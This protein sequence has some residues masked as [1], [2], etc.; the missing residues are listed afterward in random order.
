MASMVSNIF[1]LECD[2]TSALVKIHSAH[3]TDIMANAKET[4]MSCQSKLVNFS[5]FDFRSAWE[6][7]IVFGS[8]DELRGR[9]QKRSESGDLPRLSLAIFP[10]FLWML[11]DASEDLG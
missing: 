11:S 10:R 3:Y 7:P 1:R 4:P 2:T 6:K 9:V 8:T 5:T